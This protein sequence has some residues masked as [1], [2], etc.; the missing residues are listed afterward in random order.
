VNSLPDHYDTL[1]LPRSATQ[2]EIKRRYRELIREAHPDANAGDPRATARAARI[3]AAYG[4]LG[5]AERRREYDERTGGRA[6][7]RASMR[8][9]SDKVYAHWAEQENWE[10]IVAE[11]VPVRRKAHAHSDLPRIE[12]EEIAVDTSELLAERRVRRRL[13]VTNPCDC[14][15]VGEVAASEP[16]VWPPAGRFEIKP[17]ERVEFDVEIVASKVRFPGISRV[18]FVSPT[19]S[20]A[21]PVKITGFQAKPRRVV[22]ATEARY[23]AP[24]IRSRKWAR[25]RA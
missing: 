3:N 16:W 19:W 25:R 22:P 21:V 9:R 18:V 17:G 14:T 8:R 6:G 1:D 20:G 5:N 23:V 10:D 24:G 12:P 11:H 13:A 2:A 15:L 4:V 7:T